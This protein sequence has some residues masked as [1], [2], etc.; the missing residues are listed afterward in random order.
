[1]QL[2]PT[3]AAG[4]RPHLSKAPWLQQTLS[5]QGPASDLCC[6]S[7]LCPLGQLGVPRCQLLPRSWEG[8]PQHS[9]AGP[10]APRGE[11]NHWICKPWNL[12]RSLDTHITR[13]LHSVIRHRESS[14]KVGP[15]CAGCSVH[16]L[17]LATGGGGD[18]CLGP[19][20]WVPVSAVTGSPSSREPEA[21][22]LVLL[23]PCQWGALWQSGERRAPP[24]SC[25]CV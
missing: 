23:W 13:S 7:S 16:G 18:W 1:M 3:T 25:R 20:R 2:R 15:A 6:D 22:A 5:P 4:S 19:V 9:P 10:S 24:Q 12:A 14:P 8:G 21:A 11:D 17:W